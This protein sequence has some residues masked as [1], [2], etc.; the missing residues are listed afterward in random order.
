[1]RSRWAVLSLVAFCTTWLAAQDLAPRAYVITPLHANAVTFTWGYYTGGLDFNG[2]IPVQNGRGTYNVPTLSYYHSLRFFGRSANLVASL[3]YA[4]GN[5][6]GELAGNQRSV[7]RSGLAD[8]N[9]RFSVNLLG[10]P[11][12]EP[13]EFVKWTVPV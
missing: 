2:V 4:F 9:A 11:A 6:S 3:P 12:M 10:G 1:M 7:H 13:R 8:F 5:F